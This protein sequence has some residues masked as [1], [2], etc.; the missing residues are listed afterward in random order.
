MHAGEKF[1]VEES[2]PRGRGVCATFF[3]LEQSRGMTNTTPSGVIHLVSPD[4]RH[5]WTID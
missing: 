1:L 2:V 5:A 4:I 3:I